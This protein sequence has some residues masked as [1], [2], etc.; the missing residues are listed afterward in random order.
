MNFADLVMETAAAHKDKPAVIWQGGSL[1]YGELANRITHYAQKARHCERSEAIQ[2]I[3]PIAAEENGQITGEWF[4]KALGAMKA[5][6]AALP[7]S[8]NLPPGRK[9]HILEEAKTLIP[10]PGTALIYY[11]SGTAGTPKGV[12]LT[13]EN[14][15]AFCKMHAQLFNLPPAAKAAV[16]ADPGF[17]SFLLST[18]PILAQGGCLHIMSPAERISPV[19][20]HKFLMSRKID[21]TFLTTQLAVTYMKTFD[22]PHLSLLLTGGEALRSY[23]PRS[24]KVINL[25]G[26]TECTV[27]VTAHTLAEGESGDIPIGAPTGENGVIVSPEGELCICGPQVAAGYLGRPE[28]TKEKFITGPQGMKMYK[29]GDLTELS[30]HGEYLYRGRIDDQIKINGHRIE[31]G[32]VE[33]VLL[34]HPEIEAVKISVKREE[35]A[36]P[37]LIAHYVPVPQSQLTETDLRQHL[38]K[39]V[40]AYFIP[41]KFIAVKELKTNPVS[42]K[43]SA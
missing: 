20:I 35:G 30:E 40:P 13:H 4:A 17:D 26:P 27:F 18:F 21:V 2:T 10:L 37:Q 31:P 39:H 8:E 9:A 12:C 24:Y 19:G 34:S 43:V 25:Y 41:R 22:N 7:V 29:T 36:E 32:E 28:E 14:L 42:G 23:Y 1:T 5:G 33:S 6:K 15:A 11:T 3:I 38:S 16:Q